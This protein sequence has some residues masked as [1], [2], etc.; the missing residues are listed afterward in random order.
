MEWTVGLSPEVKRRHLHIMEGVHACTGL[1]DW[2]GRKGRGGTE[3]ERERKTQASPDKDAIVRAWA[4]S[5]CSRGKVS[6][7]LPP[8]GRRERER[9]D[10]PLWL[11]PFWL[12]SE[13]TPGLSHPCKTLVQES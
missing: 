11:K 4:G 3:S 9:E 7:P 6:P 1:Q 8:E 5:A 12:K 2:I 10:V 13:P